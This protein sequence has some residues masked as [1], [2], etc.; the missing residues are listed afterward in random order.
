MMRE[1][2]KNRMLAIQKPSPAV[3]G[4]RGRALRRITII[5]FSAIV[6]AGCSLHASRLNDV[7]GV[8][9][10]SYSRGSNEPAQPAGRWWEEFGDEKLNALVEQVFRHNLD[11]R[12]AYERLA[13]SRALAGIADSARGPVVNVEGSGGRARQSSAGAVLTDDVYR[14]SAAAGFELDLW[15]RLK[16]LS[17]SARLEAQASEEDLRSLF[18]SIS[19]QAADLYYLAEEQQLQIELSDRTIASF[20]ETLNRVERRYREGLVPAIDVYQSRQNLSSAKAQRPLFAQNRA[21]T[22]N[23][24]SVLSGLAPDAEKER[25]AAVLPEAPSFNAGL[26]SQLLDRRPDVRAAL[27]RIQASDERVSAAIAD[28]F[29]SFNLV[30]SYGGASDRVRTV[31]DSPN[32]FWNILLEAA[33]P[34]IDSGRRRAEVDRTEAVLQESLAAYHKTVLEAL[35]DVE[36]ALARGAASEERIAMLEETVISSEAS[37]RLALDRYLQG[38]TDYLPVLTEQLRSFTTQSNL[39][40]ARRQLISDRI[41]LARA[42]GG[43]WADSVSDD[44]IGRMAER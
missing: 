8:V 3:S 17:E 7:S 16:S 34:V 25:S 12:Q 1:V 30:G 2:G 13:Q 29:P 15:G 39:L 41:Q 40:A 10:S 38:L 5:L 18:I 26:P 21:V 6:L 35:A 36:D 19:A 23:A 32:I 24:L 28:R 14:L 42:L 27:F 31:L 37:L 44:Y 43:T 33:Q 11:I 9:P 22:L 4:L 20:Q